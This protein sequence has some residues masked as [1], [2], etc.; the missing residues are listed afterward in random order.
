MPKTKS[1][2]SQLLDQEILTRILSSRKYRGLDIPQ[3][4]LL[5]LLSR[6]K[7]LTQDPREIEHIVREKMHNLVAPYLGDPDYSASKEKLTAAYQSGDEQTIKEV[8]REIL[9][10]HAS[11]RERISLLDT[12]YPRLFD[13]TGVPQTVVDLACALNPFTLPWMGLPAKAKYY[14]YDLHFPRLQLINYFLLLNHFEPLAI[15]Q[16]ILVNPPGVEADVAFFFKEAHRF[17]QRRHGCNREF[18]QALKVKYLLVSLPTSS[19]TGRHS[20]IEQHRRLV[21]DTVAGM[22][23]KV[24]EIL[25]DNEI[26]FCIEKSE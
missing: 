2:T 24:K 7:V 13:I 11:T 8:C 17:D 14:A 10:A 16:D 6:A 3:E 12:F 19:L 15:H 5:D 20:K 22:N 26:V 18:W 9:L 21:M 23:W 4:T 25:F 1:N